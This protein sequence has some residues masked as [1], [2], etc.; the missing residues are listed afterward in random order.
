M[1]LCVDCKKTG[2][3]FNL[4]N[5]KPE[6]CKKCSTKYKDMVNVKHIICFEKDCKTRAGYNYENEKNVKYCSKHKKTGM[7]DKAHKKCIEKKCSVR[8]SF[9][10]EN[11][12]TPIYC[13]THMKDGMVNIGYVKCKFDKCNKNA[14]YSHDDKKLREFCGNHKKDG[15][16]NIVNKTCKEKNCNSSP[17]YNYENETERLYC[18]THKKDGMVNVKHKKCIFDGCETI[19]SYNYKDRK[20]GMY[21]NTHKKENMIDIITK[22]C[23]SEWCDTVASNKNYK[24]YCAYCFTHLF[25]DEPVSRLY[26]NKERLVGE[27]IKEQFKDITLTFDKKIAGS[28][29]KQ[30]PDIYIDMGFQYI[31]IEVD[32]NQHK[33]DNYSCENKRLMLIYNALE[34]RKMVVIRFNPDAYIDKKYGKIAGCINKYGKIKS[35]KKN[36]WN[37]RLKKLKECVDKYIKNEIEKAVQIEYLFYDEK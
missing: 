13:E 11:E 17:T 14:I 22:K 32:E 29:I 4:K 28:C 15:M 8:P 1:V 26:K 6:Y 10:F 5:L 12:K 16:I 24:G 3:S 35:C 37:N 2:A 9:N 18:E 25:P 34:Y 7:V 36:E 21:C 27:Y 23:L 31:I 20:N 19:S 33:S 30:R